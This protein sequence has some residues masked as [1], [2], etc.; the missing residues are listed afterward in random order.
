MTIAHRI[1]HGDAIRLGCMAGHQLQGAP[2]MRCWYGEWTSPQPQCIA[3]P[4]ALPTIRNGYYSGGYRSGLTI[5]HGSVI[6]FHCKPNYVRGVQ[7]PPRCFEGRLMPEPPHCIEHDLVM[8]VIDDKAINADESVISVPKTQ[9]LSPTGGSE[10]TITYNTSTPSEMLWCE[11]PDKLENVLKYES[12]FSANHLPLIS[13]AQINSNDNNDDNNNTTTAQSTTADSTPSTAAPIT[14]TPITATTVFAKLIEMTTTYFT[15][16]LN[17]TDLS[18]GLALSAA[19]NKSVDITDTTTAAG[20]QEKVYH[21]H[22]TEIVFNCLPAMN[23]QRNTWTITC[24]DGGWIGRASKCGKKDNFTLHDIFVAKKFEE[25]MAAL[26]LRKNNTCVYTNVDPNVW[27]FIGDQ[28]IEEYTELSAGT[29]LII[30]CKDIGKYNLIGSKTRKCVYGE[31]DGD[32]PQ[33]F[34]LSQEN[35]YA[36]EKPPTILFRHQLGPIAQSVDGKLIVYPGTILH[37]ECLWKRK[38]GAP[39]W[40]W[41]HSFRKYNQDWTT[42]S[43]RDSGLEFRLSIFHAQKEDSGLYTCRTPN[44]HRH[45][46]EI[47]VKPVHCSAL[48]ESDGLKIISPSTK[49]NAKALFTCRPGMKLNGT[50]SAECL[51]SGNWSAD[52][53]TC[54]I[55]ECPDLTNSTD[56]TITDNQTDP[57]SMLKT[58]MNGRYVEVFC[59]T[60]VIP[61]HGYLQGDKIQRFRG[62]DIVQFTCDTGYMLEGNPIV[63]CQENSRWSGPPPNCVPACTYPGTTHGGIISIVKFFYS[64]NET[65]RFECADGYDMRG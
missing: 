11:P 29:Q 40:E 64:V 12:T 20:P 44:Y 2:T 56:I 3:A 63:I 35:D 54:I 57:R 19:D 60:P 50:D 26:E 21:P 39:V 46:V 42:E 65:V 8:N 51:P 52:T 5:S 61:T 33:C 49:M 55:T 45:S 27:A 48:V 43:G 22:G 7:E 13:I 34:G 59:E 16:F 10:S 17:I 14:T 28:R 47:I 9:V 62:G 1:S 53:P 31:W 18:K 24:E 36:L 32:R 38:F 25:D 58:T 41:S 37:L 6:E 15:D 30:R 23:G 4:C